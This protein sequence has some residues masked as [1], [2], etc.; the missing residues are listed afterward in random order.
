VRRDAPQLAVWAVFGI[1]AAV[2]PGQAFA[3]N[4]SIFQLHLF[5]P[6]FLGLMMPLNPA[7]L[8]AILFLSI[9]QLSHQIVFFGGLSRWP[10]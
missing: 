7:K 6:V 9:F 2:L 4:D 5:W 3:I 10:D 1:A 8:V